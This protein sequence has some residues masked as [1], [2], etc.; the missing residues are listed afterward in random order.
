MIALGEE[1]VWAGGSGQDCTLSPPF[2][3]GDG[4]CASVRGVGRMM[5]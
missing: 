5:L 3:G 4:L 1:G 2:A